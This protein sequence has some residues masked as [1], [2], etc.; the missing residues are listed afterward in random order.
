VAGGGVFRFQ[1]GSL[2]TVNLREGVR[3][4]DVSDM[5]HLVGHLTESYEITGGIERFAG[6]SGQLSLTATLAVVLYDASNPPSA[7]LLTLTGEVEGTVSG[8][9]PDED[10]ETNGISRR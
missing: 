7:V 4:V 6:A 3:C 2:L 9:A 5:N 1:N 8:L 10:G